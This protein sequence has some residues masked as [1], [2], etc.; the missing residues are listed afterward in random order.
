MQTGYPSIDKPWLKYYDWDFSESEIP[1]LSIYQLAVESNKNNMKKIAI[2]LRSSATNYSIGIKITYKEFFE[3]IQET[4]KASYALGIQKREIVPIIL[5]NIP[6]ARI[7]IYSNSILGA[8]SYPI[9]PLLPANQ[10]KDLIDQNGIKNVFIFKMF[11][12]KYL[13]VLRNCNIENIILLDGTESI[14]APLRVLLKIK[15]SFSKKQNES[16]DKNVIFWSEYQKAGKNIVHKIDP[17]YEENH[18]TA[19]IGT[20][21]T[22]GTPK[23]V[24]LT[25]RNIN[26]VALAYKNGKLLEGTMMDVLLP[27][28]GYGISMLHYQTVAGK[29]VYL[30]PELL[31]TT[32]TDVL[33]KLRPDNFAGGPVHFINLRA[34][35]QFEGGILP[36]FNNLISGGASLPKDVERTLNQVPEDYEESGVNKN[37]IVRQGFGLSENVA[38][39]TY[40][41]WGAYKFGSIG[42]PAPY[43]TISIFES[44]TDKELKYNEAG[45]ICI[46]GPSVMMGY[47]NNKEETDKVLIPHSDG[48][49]WI[50]TKDIGYM[51]EKGHIFHVDRIKNIFMRTGFNVHPST[52]ADYINTISFVK[53]C[54]VIGFEHPAE[55]SVPIAFLETENTNLTDDEMTEKLRKDCYETLEEPSVPYAFVFVDELPINVGGKI[56]I[57]KIRELSKIDLMNSN[58]IAKTLSFKI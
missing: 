37:L 20:S 44:G 26:T 4:A 31:T 35:K 11:L 9:S 42:I 52:I 51:D 17:F 38:M 53:N 55:Q 15:S 58:D 54:V 2:D 39:G 56:D 33:C 12:P 47:L 32:F 57:Q 41:K 1:N 30:I 19:I 24:C 45:E 49:L 25:D 23:G 36:K 48:K 8:V 28:I 22:T 13:E 7:L 27:S 10:L 3:R 5:P 18:I 29:Y 43:I 16:Y 46:T 50:H 21:G 34:S 14:S 40:S 6:E